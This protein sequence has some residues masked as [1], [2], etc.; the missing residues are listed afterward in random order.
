M[1]SGLQRYFFYLQ[2]VKFYLEEPRFPKSVG[3]VFPVGQV[4]LCDVF[5]YVKFLCE[6]F[7][8]VKFFLVCEVFLLYVKCE[9]FR[10]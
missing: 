10:M 4:F 8:Y 6:V 3:Q 1:F 2:K 9:V 7:L 5:L